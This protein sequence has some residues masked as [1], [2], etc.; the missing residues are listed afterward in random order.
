MNKKHFKSFASFS[1]FEEFFRGEDEDEGSVCSIF[2]YPSF[3]NFMHMHQN[4]NWEE[5][6]S[7]FEFGLY[8]AP[9]GMY[10]HTSYSCFWII[11]E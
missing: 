7:F 11:N 3:S 10:H 1:L 9:H 6:D 2:V 4:I 8:V 5:H